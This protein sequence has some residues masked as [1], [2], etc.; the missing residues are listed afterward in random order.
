MTITKIDRDTY[1]ITMNASEMMTLSAL[2]SV[3][4]TGFINWLQRKGKRTQEAQWV[5]VK[6]VEK[7]QH[8]MSKAVE[9]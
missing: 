1:Q 8:S 4:K 6:E 9:A 7:I 3:M 2:L 5:Y